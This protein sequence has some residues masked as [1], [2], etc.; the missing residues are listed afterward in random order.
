MFYTNVRSLSRARLPRYFRH[1]SLTQ[2]ELLRHVNQ[3]IENLWLSRLQ[4]TDRLPRVCE[5]SAPHSS[6]IVDAPLHVFHEA[7]AAGVFLVLPRHAIEGC[8]V[9][10][11]GEGWELL[12]PAS[13]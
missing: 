4:P 2:P 10:G 12:A 8:T 7:V 3:E 9:V 6:A 11:R 1:M 5:C 13:A